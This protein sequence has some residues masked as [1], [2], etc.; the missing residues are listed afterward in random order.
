MLFASVG[1]ARGAFWSKEWTLKA[2]W[3]I[4]LCIAFLLVGAW[5]EFLV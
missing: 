1:T 2:N 4:Y 3:Q 5:I